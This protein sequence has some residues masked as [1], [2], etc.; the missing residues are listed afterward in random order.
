MPL[1]G[2]AESEAGDERW[3]TCD[4]LNGNVTHATQPTSSC[5]SLP[6]KR[7]TTAAGSRASHLSR[8]VA[9]VRPHP[10]RLVRRGWPEHRRLG[11]LARVRPERNRASLAGHGAQRGVLDCTRWLTARI[12]RPLLVSGRDGSRP[13]RSEYAGDATMNT[14]ILEPATATAQLHGNHFDY[15]RVDS[16]D[17]RRRVRLHR[18]PSERPQNRILPS[19]SATCRTLLLGRVATSSFTSKNLKPRRAFATEAPGF[20]SRT[21][22]PDRFQRGW[23]KR[24]QDDLPQYEV[25]AARRIYNRSTI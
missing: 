3:S 20:V 17:G 19:E 22:F 9:R 4:V 21:K 23:A 7:G 24:A 10:S 13:T 2:A 18:P 6:R 11:Q 1:R 14:P 16:G 25:L 15:P 8:Q 12:L 5:S